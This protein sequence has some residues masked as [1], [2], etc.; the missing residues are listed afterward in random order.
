MDII[1]LFLE[2][3]EVKIIIISKDIFISMFIM[4]KGKNKIKYNKSIKRLF[5]PSILLYR[6]NLVFFC[7]CFLYLYHIISHKDI[8]I[9]VDEL[10]FSMFQYYTC[11]L[12]SCSG[13]FFLLKRVI[14]FSQYILL[15][16]DHASLFIS[17]DTFLNIIY[18]IMCCDYYYVMHD[19]YKFYYDT[20]QVYAL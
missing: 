18:S 16:T 15:F 7:V 14:W 13:F 8:F 17:F 19:L 6:I 10:G 9:Y 1:L 2:N 12:V 3:K 4:L 5:E 20:F 11:F